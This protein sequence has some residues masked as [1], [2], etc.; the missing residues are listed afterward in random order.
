MDKFVCRTHG[1]IRLFTVEYNHLFHR[2]PWQNQRHTFLYYHWAKSIVHLPYE[3]TG[4]YP[5][6]VGKDWQ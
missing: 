2:F 5:N 1:G 6:V 3:R 4:R